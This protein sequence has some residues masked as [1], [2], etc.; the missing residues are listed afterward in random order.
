ML[1]SFRLI[2][3]KVGFNLWTQNYKLHTLISNIIEFNCP[4]ANYLKS[5]TIVCKYY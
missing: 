2:G 4:Y 5:G 1:K 3:H